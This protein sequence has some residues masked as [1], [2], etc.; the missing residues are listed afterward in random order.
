MA[1]QFF[2]FLSTHQSGILMFLLLAATVMVL[3]NWLLWLLGKGRY[4]QPQER[5]YRESIWR[6]VFS[7]FIVRLIDE[8]RHLLALV[9]VVIFAVALAY[10]LKRAGADTTGTTNQAEAATA[11]VKNMGEAIETVMAS[12]GS[13]VSIIIGY[14]FGRAA[15]TREVGAAPPAGGASPGAPGDTPA[16]PSAPPPEKSALSPSL[17]QPDEQPSTALDSQPG[18]TS[19]G[20][21]T[22]SSS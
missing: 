10:V 2:D 8:F 1:G 19:H 4:G 9:V 15:V 11:L 7:K 22:E 20:A 12:L 21:T 13:L 16:V 14:Y 3:F 18:E 17:R 6:F 5:P